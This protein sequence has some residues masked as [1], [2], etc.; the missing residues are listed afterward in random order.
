MDNSQWL[1]IIHHNQCVGCGSCVAQCPTHA[2]ERRGGKAALVRP[3]ACIYC[4]TCETLC[5][6][7]AIEIPY[8]VCSADFST[9]KVT[10]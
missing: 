2:L 5:P 7:N 3:E 1:P 8:Q 6:Y 4:A 9:G 10:S